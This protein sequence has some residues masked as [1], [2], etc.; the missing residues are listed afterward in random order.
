M[1]VIDVTPGAPR[2][3]HERRTSMLALA[4]ALALFAAVG[5]RMSRFDAGDSDSAE[6]S[7][8][9]STLAPAE[10]RREL[11]LVERETIDLF[12]DNSPSVVHVTSAARVRRA[13]RDP[14]D[15]PIGT[16]TGFVW[17]EKGH[18]VTNF[19]VIAAVQ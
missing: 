1:R 7:A 14:V 18:I 11:R 10:P 13:F 19:H 8:P 6:T 5:W 12:R 3:T 16:G 2:P 4:S 15:L 17:D 9:Q